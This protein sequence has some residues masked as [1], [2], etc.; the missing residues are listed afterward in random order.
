M[1]TCPRTRTRTCTR[2]W[3]HRTD[4]RLLGLGCGPG[5]GQLSRQLLRVRHRAQ[6]GLG[7][8]KTPRPHAG[9]QLQPRDAVA[10][11]EGQRDVAEAV[12]VAAQAGRRDAAQRHV[13]GHREHDA[14][15]QHDALVGQGVDGGA[16]RQ[17]GQQGDAASADQGQRQQPAQRQQGLR[18][19]RTRADQIDAVCRHQQREIQADL[20][21]MKDPPRQRAEV[22]RALPQD[23]LASGQA[24]GQSVLRLELMFVGV[25]FDAH[26][27]LQQS[28]LQATFKPW[29]RCVSGRRTACRRRST[30]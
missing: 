26:L 20:A 16:G 10:A 7:L 19:A 9:P 1:R 23:A 30:R 8:G 12:C 28:T 22:G 21:Q 4:R 2:D 3:M 17:P 15:A 29:T 14:H 6:H 24:F 18:R 25:A 11:P 27:G 13:E 5:L